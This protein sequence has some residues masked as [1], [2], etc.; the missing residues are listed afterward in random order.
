MGLIQ[1]K[2]AFNK[3]LAFILCLCIF[4][5]SLIIFAGCNESATKYY[6]G[7][8]RINNASLGISVV[9]VGISRDEQGYYVEEGRTFY[10]TLELAGGYDIGTIA[11]YLNNSRIQMIPNTNTTN[12]E[13]NRLRNRYISAISYTP[14]DTF[15]IT[16]DGEAEK[17]DYT[18]NLAYNTSSNDDVLN[19][20]TL[21][22]DSKILTALGVPRETSMTFL[23]FKELMTEFDFNLPIE[24][25]TYG[26]TFTITVSPNC[27]NIASLVTLINENDT[28]SLN[29]TSYSNPLDNDTDFTI[30]L[31][32]QAERTLTLTINDAVL[33]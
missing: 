1:N 5:P 24:N 30:N 22:L 4:L 27:E 32:N 17:W 19:N 6:Y 29:L 16:A 7:I 9:D 11:V 13:P 31:L 26:D 33:V 3:I 18:L 14:T 20:Y 25:L 12:T 2:K 28:Q 15:R 23:R 21:R 10:V 8:G